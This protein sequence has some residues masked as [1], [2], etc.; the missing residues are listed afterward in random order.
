MFVHFLFSPWQRGGIATWV[1]IPVIDAASINHKQLQE[2]ILKTYCFLGDL[3]HLQP[4][5][6]DPA[7]YRI[8]LAAIRAEYLNMVTTKCFPSHVWFFL[9]L[10]F[11]IKDLSPVCLVFVDF[12]NVMFLLYSLFQYE[13][14]LLLSLA[15]RRADRFLQNEFLYK[16][17]FLHFPEEDKSSFFLVIS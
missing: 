13:F 4:H 12:F 15:D 6:S 17:H 1:C 3:L 11:I 10:F 14:C 2:N 7:A 8:W 16:M 5:T 9:L